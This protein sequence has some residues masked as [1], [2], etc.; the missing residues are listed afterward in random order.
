MHIDNII[1]Q[2]FDGK[3]L[4]RNL[5]AIQ[6]LMV[7]RVGVDF[8]AKPPAVIAYDAL[9]ICRAF[10]GQD[11]AWLEA[12]RAT[13]YQNPYSVLIGGD[14]GPDTYDGTIWQVLPLDEVGFHA[15]RWSRGY[16][17]I[18]CI[19][20]FRCK[21]PSKSQRSSLV[22]TLAVLCGRL[23]LQPY[24]HIKGHGEVPEAHDGSKAPGKPGACPGD[25]LDMHLVRD[26]VALVMK[27]RSTL[28]LS[29]ELFIATR[30]AGEASS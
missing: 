11:P 28:H 17:G 5:S 7:H 8:R 23:G 27:A 9:G 30:A 29:D 15:R 16:L 21:P 12:A 14:C 26:D 22:F 24:K 1:A 18:A 20:D 10:Q 3:Y 2:A 6:G 13:G 19:G 4:E 25:L